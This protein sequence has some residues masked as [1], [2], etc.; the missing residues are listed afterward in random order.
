MDNEELGRSV[1]SDQEVDEIDQQMLES[2]RF[3]GFD[4]EEGAKAGNRED[5]PT[6]KKT[7]KEIYE[8]V[9]KKSKKAKHERQEF[10]EDYGEKVKELDDELM[11][12]GELLA[13]RKKIKVA[14]T[15]ES[16]MDD[17]QL[18]ALKL[19]GERVL[20]PQKVEKKVD[21]KAEE[22]RKKKIINELNSDSDEC[23]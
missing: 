1:A 6:K 10:K 21:N 8:E 14:N 19:S 3:Q 16:E 22:R 12:I 13:T 2:L 23:D 11:G 7:R 5:A 18:M 15:A 20:G 9:I 17:Y 4:E